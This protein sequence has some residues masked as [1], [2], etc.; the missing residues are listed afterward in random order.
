MGNETDVKAQADDQAILDQITAIIETEMGITIN[1]DVSLLQVVGQGH[2][3]INT[4]L[5]PFNGKGDVVSEGEEQVRGPPQE[6]LP[7]YID[8]YV[9]VCS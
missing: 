1:R 9:S 4:L 8:F 6:A 5:H 3:D 2:F 7:C